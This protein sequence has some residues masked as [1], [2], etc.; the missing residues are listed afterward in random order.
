MRFIHKFQSMK[1]ALVGPVTKDF[2]TID[3]NLTIYIG[4]PAYYC[5]VALH[6]LGVEVEVFATYSAQD[7]EFVQQGFGG[8]RVHRL[9]VEKTMESHITYESVT[10][11][12]RQVEICSFDNRITMSDTLIQALESFDYILLGP[13]F[14]DNIPQEFFT[15][16]R[17]KKLVL[18]NFGMF[19]YEEQGRCVRK[20]P[21]NLI[22]ILPTLEY[23][24]LDESE[25][26][27]VSGQDTIQAAA[28]YLR[29][30]GLKN[31]IVTEGSR[32]SHLFLDGTEYHIPAF[33]PRTLVDTTGA[34][35]T[36]EVAFI[37][38]LEIF[39]DPNDQGRFAAMVATMSLEN[40]GAFRGTET[41]VLSRLKECEKEEL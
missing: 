6:S 2:I 40:R 25:V 17:Q 9:D 14:H 3:G 13:L 26:L 32:G 10:P 11:D 16:L 8:I 34:G 15:A 36:Y 27:F 4:S 21:E 41:E 1:I 23:L 20:N 22:A 38:A 12:T 7:E 19:T 24:F 39:D 29:E 28:K 31:L 18:G 33:P 35:D 37:R 5:A 30:K